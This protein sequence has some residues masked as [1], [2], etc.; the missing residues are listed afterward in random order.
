MKKR[1]SLRD[2]LFALIIC[3]A[4]CG[5]GALYVGTNKLDLQV[6]EWLTM[7]DA[8]YLQGYWDNVNVKQHVSVDGFTSGKLQK[9]F[10]DFMS[11][12]IPAKG[13]ALL[14]NAALQ[15]SAIVASNALF[16]WPCY[17]S[18]YNSDIGVDVAQARLFEIPTQVTSSTQTAVERTAQS[19]TEF[20]DRHP[21]LRTF[22]YLGTDAAH[23]AD[24]VAAP[25]M[26]SP[27]TYPKLREAFLANKGEA[28]TWID[29][30]VTYNDYL[31]DWY[32]TDH[33]WNTRGAFEGYTRI[34]TALGFGNELLSPTDIITLDQPRFYGAMARLGLD[35]DYY[36]NIVDYKFDSFPHYAVAINGEEVEESELFE[37]DLDAV[38]WDQN[39][40]AN[41]YVEYFHDDYRE[42][43]LTNPESTSEDVLLIVG[44]SYTN[45]IERFLA[46]HY[47]TTYVFDPRKDSSTLDA[48]LASHT[49]VS[50]VVFLMRNANMFYKTTTNTLLPQNVE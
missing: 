37:T 31:T 35:G 21:E 38:A 12:N 3:V 24:S 44:D 1:I 30:E 18:F 27:E 50:D 5:P 22:V 15:R 13:E 4:F 41:R 17:P 42:I 11:E 36:D 48:Y 19:M 10:E 34:A 28:L 23:L 32:K 25:L 6:P 45:C 9:A 29:G 39:R 14:T 20:A 43:T 40:Y 8:R 49:D 26:S 47:K 46:A 33:H 2:I 16:G 7:N